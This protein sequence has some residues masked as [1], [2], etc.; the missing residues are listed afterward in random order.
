MC[1]T[2]CPPCPILMTISFCAGS[3]VRAEVGEI[4]VRSSERGLVP[5]AQ[6]NSLLSGSNYTVLLH[7]FRFRREEGAGKEGPT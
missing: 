4:R 5:T 1:R 6:N 3:E 7:M 2:C